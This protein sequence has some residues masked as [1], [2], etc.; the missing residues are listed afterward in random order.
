MSV[1]NLINLEW[2]GDGSDIYNNYKDLYVLDDCYNKTTCTYATATCTWRFKMT[3][4]RKF[5]YAGLLSGLEHCGMVL[6]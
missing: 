3:K 1:K 6:A 4:K 5:H 2:L